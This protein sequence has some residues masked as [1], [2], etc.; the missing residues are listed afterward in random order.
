MKLP[1]FG[2]ETEER[3]FWKKHSIA[4][5]WKDLRKSDDTFERPRPTAEFLVLNS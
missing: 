5:Y 2:T 1:N 4:D 3:E